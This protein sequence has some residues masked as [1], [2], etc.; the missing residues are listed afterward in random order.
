MPKFRIIDQRFAEIETRQAFQEDLIEQLNN[1]LIALNE[2]LI[3][4]YQLIDR[5]EQKLS[6]IPNSQ[7]ASLSEETPPPHY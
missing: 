5:L 2:R 6:S 7:I 1:E 3:S 4:S